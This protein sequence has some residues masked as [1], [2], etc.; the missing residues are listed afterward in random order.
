LAWLR[1]EENQFLSCPPEIARTLPEGLLRLMGYQRGA[2][3]L[4]Y[5]DDLREP[6][7]W[8]YDLPSVQTDYYA[9]RRSARALLKRT[10][11]YAPSTE[12]NGS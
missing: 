2:V 9:Y 5:V 11:P 7:D 12:S 8:L 1:Q 6:I 10:E 3:G 4:G